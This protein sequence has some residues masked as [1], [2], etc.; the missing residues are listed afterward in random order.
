MK[1]FIAFLAVSVIAAVLLLYGF[2][3]YTA[4][5]AL[6]HTDPVVNVLGAI[7]SAILI[8]GINNA[9]NNTKSRSVGGR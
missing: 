6:D 4:V 2:L 9:V 7:L 5:V 3:I 1:I 8:N